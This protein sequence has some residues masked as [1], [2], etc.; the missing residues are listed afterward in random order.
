MGPMRPRLVL[1]LHLCAAMLV[2]LGCSDDP[3][4]GTG[5]QGSGGGGA[6]SGGAGGCAAGSCGAGGAGSGPTCDQSIL[7]FAPGACGVAANDACCEQMQTC[8]ST[9]GCEVALICTL[10]P[11]FPD[12]CPDS[13]E[14]DAVIECLD[15]L[16]ECAP[17]FGVC[18]SAITISEVCDECLT[19]GCCDAFIA[20]ADGD[21]DAFV[22]CLNGNA[23][24]DATMQPA[25]DCANAR[26]A[27]ECPTLGN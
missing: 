22:A 19:L 26:C 11:G 2:V 15:S 16:V 6:G 23:P 20:G 4:Q 5:G 1:W 18:T 8:E 3:A 7:T 12:P 25:V 10:T 17:S 9:P 27:E 21:R 24:C 14:R 13:T